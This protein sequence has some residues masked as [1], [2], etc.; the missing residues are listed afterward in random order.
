LSLGSELWHSVIRAIEMSIP[1][2]DSVNAKV[3]FG[4]AQKVRDYAA[5]QL[6]VEDGMLILDAGIGPGTMSQTVISK[7]SDL[8]IVGLDASIEL[9]NAARARL[10]PSHADRLNLVRGVFEALPFRDG[11]FPRIVSAFAFRDAR[12]RSI[13]IDEFYRVNDEKG[14]FLI[15][16]LGKPVNRLKR[17]GIS[18]HVH[19]VAPFIARLSMSDAIQ[20]NPW[21]MLFPTY[22]E[23]ATNGELVQALRVR[24][25]GV[26]LKEFA[27]GGLIVISATRV[28]SGQIGIEVGAPS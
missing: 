23:V 8:T 4:L 13:A 10:G 18:I 16:D 28:G 27:F 24:Y 6:Q 14:I 3:T 25:S 22:Q 21:R 11:C 17:A 9:L 7:S 20:G 15:V 5:T 1:E 12:N 26:N 19:Y 2:Y